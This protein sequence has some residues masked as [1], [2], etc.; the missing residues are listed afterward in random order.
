VLAGAVGSAGIGGRVGAG[1]GSEVEAHVAALEV[2]AALLVVRLLGGLRAVEVDVAEATRAARL[3]VGNDAGASDALKVLELLVQGV[4]IDAPAEVANP[5]GGTLLGSLT[6]LRLV[7]LGRSLGGLGLLLGLPLL[8]R[9]LSSS[10]LLLSRL[11]LLGVI[12]RVV[13]AGLAV[14]ILIIVLGL[15]SMG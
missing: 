4:V 5:E 15:G 7:L 11:G 8:G 1:L 2:R 12:L 14:L 3:L 9:L 10:G 6:T 13:S